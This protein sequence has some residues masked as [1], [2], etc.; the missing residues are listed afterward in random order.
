MSETNGIE[1]GMRVRDRWTGLEGIA[2]AW[3]EWLYGGGRRI[4]VQ[5]TGT[6]DG[7]PFKAHWIPVERL[8]VRS[9]Q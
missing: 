9:A 5:P 6:K 1:L 7:E 2:E 4:R 8:E 3:D